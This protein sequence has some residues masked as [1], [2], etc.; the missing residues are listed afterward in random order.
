MLIM[1]E[2]STIQQKRTLG[3]HLDIWV[4]AP[5]SLER[6]A[7]GKQIAGLVDLEVDHKSSRKSVSDASC[8]RPNRNKQ[9]R[10]G[11]ASARGGLH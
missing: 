7:S 8:L 11:C 2:V 1:M 3:P 6:N 4:L 9:N 10:S 5:G